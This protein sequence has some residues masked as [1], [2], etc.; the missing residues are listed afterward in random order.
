MSVISLESLRSFFAAYG[1]LAAFGLGVFEEL[2]FFIPST[3]FF[4]ALGFFAIS[5]NLGFWQALPIAIFDLGVVVSLGIL[6]G[7]IAV[8]FLAYLGGKPAILKW[9]S[10]ARVRWEDIGRLHRIFDERGAGVAALFFLRVVPAFPIGIVSIFCGLVRVRFRDFAW[11]TFLGS[12]P[13]VAGLS[14]LGWYLG[15]GHARYEPHIAAF[16]R[17]FL[18]I[19]L[20]ALSV[21]LVRA[22]A[23]IRRRA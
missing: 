2:A 18:I 9:G 3:M 21:L 14:M 10:Y 11:I 5:P 13:R 7:G 20:L 4:V 16:E 15:K 17:Y 1:L 23:R 6:A 12:I 8:Y 19:V 22:R